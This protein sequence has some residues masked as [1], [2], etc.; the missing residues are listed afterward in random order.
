[1]YSITDVIFFY[2]KPHTKYFDL[3]K[4]ILDQVLSVYGSENEWNLKDGGEKLTQE[5][6]ATFFQNYIANLGMSDQVTFEF[7][8]NTVA[9]TS[10]VHSN[11]E[12]LSKV[13][14][15][16][17]IQYRRNRIM[18]VLNHEIG[19]HFIRK[20]NDKFQKWHKHR[21][22]YDM[23]TYSKIEEGLATVNQLYETGLSDQRRPYLFR[24]A[25]LY[26]ACV[27]ASKMSFQELFK[28]LGAY[29]QDP[30]DRWT[31]GVRVKRGIAD[32]SQSQG[33]YKDQI[34]LRGVIKVLKYRKQLNF[35]NLH[36]GKISVSDCIRLTEKN[37]IQTEKCKIPYFL[38]NINLYQKVLDRIAEINFLV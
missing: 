4:K 34:Y 36:A 29:I 11:T 32:T 30:E 33:Q 8:E 22:K 13:I 1:M 17:P 12:G 27:L 21:K 31:Y 15:G 2:Q 16:L 35:Y 18:G 38:Q 6:T 7:A 24:A 9:S 26:Y 25:L 20:Y 14:I 5:E 3:A 37:V 19:T 23:Q 28:V 10:C